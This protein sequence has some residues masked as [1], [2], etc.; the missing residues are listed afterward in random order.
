MKNHL[1]NRHKA[2][3]YINTDN[4]IIGLQPIPSHGH[5]NC[6]LISKETVE[7]IIADVELMS[8]I[9]H[10]AHLN[11]LS[12]VALAKKNPS[13]PL[14]IFSKKLYHK[15]NKFGNSV[16]DALLLHLYHLKA[17]SLDG[18][19]ERNSK[20]YVVWL[21]NGKKYIS[22]AGVVGMGDLP[23]SMEGAPANNAEFS[24]SINEKF[25]NPIVFAYATKRVRTLHYML[26]RQSSRT[27]NQI[28]KHNEVWLL[29]EPKI[30]SG[31]V[32]YTTSADIQRRNEER[33]ALK[34][35]QREQAAM[36]SLGATQS[37]LNK[38]A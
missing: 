33:A 37:T 11:F 16:K 22:L 4:T 24:A 34:H 14:A 32:L 30:K 7:S 31:E 20:K 10:H 5:F 28:N 6:D 17:C 12:A 27:I 35:S 19:F 36:Q 13:D 29:L 3:I 23:V 18:V 8:E 26:Q 25:S 2:A 15:N 38:T 1:T 9:S 21:L